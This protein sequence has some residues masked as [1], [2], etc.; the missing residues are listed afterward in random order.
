MSVPIDITDDTLASSLSSSANKANPACNCLFLKTSAE[1]LSKC[2]EGKKLCPQN[3]DCVDKEVIAF[4]DTCHF[5][6]F[7]N[8]EKTCTTQ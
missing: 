8:A 3:D 5:G 2:C 4:S 7:K 1:Q 6:K